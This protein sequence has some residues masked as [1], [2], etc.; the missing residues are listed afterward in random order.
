MVE[1][2]KVAEM[3][4]NR[5]KL[6]WFYPFKIENKWHIVAPLLKKE[7]EPFKGRFDGKKW[8][9]EPTRAR[10]NY[11]GGI[12]W[13]EPPGVVGPD[14]ACGN[15]YLNLSLNFGGDNGIWPNPLPWTITVTV[16][17]VR[18]L[19]SCVAIFL[20]SAKPVGFKFFFGVQILF[21]PA[22]NRSHTIS[23]GWW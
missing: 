5:Y 6:P 15:C 7:Y 22:A 13:T 11:E 4:W 20:V 14:E 3:P 1:C 18:L 10:C 2:S 21:A 12:T 16:F 17:Q 23:I 19:P 9:D 8:I